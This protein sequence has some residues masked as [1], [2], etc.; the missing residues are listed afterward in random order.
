[1]I[2]LLGAEGTGTAELAAALAERLSRR[3]IPALPVCDGLRD[4]CAPGRAEAAA[5][6]AEQMRRI[7]AAANAGV[8]VADGSALSTAVHFDLAQHD[9][10]LYLEALAAHR[11][12]AIT[13]LMACDTPTQAATDARLRAALARGR[14]TYAVVHGSGAQRLAN[15]WNAILAFADAA[16]DAPAGDGKDAWTWPCEKCTDPRCEHRLFT[17]LLARRHA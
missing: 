5:F 3:G 16:Q 7:A 4:W 1:V 10:A 14:I 13:L 2:A 11:R 9:D 12:H 17:D 6:M 8:A 15:A